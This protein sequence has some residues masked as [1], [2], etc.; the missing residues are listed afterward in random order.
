M[1][2][3]K[4]KEATLFGPE[5]VGP[6][7]DDGRVVEGKVVNAAKPK[8]TKGEVAVLPPPAPQN[9]LSIIASAAANPA[10][11]VAKMKELLAMQREIEVAEQERAF[12]AAMHA[13]QSEMPRITK[14][15]KADRFTYATLENVSLKIDPIARA[16]GFVL[17]YGSL[18]PATPGNI[19][20]YVDVMHVGGA[21]RR[22]IAP[23][24]KPDT[25]GLKDGKNKTD[26]QGAGASISYM[27]RYLKL[28]VFDVAIAGEDT[29]GKRKRGDEFIT[30]QQVELL[31]EQLEAVE[32]PRDK[33]L[34]FMKV[35][36]LA[37]IP[38]NLF[39]AGIDALK[40]FDEKRREKAAKGAA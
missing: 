26:T 35:E 34:A 18:P 17:S 27:R 4:A 40:A 33:F 15:K 28:M 14:D 39:Q 16:H 11:D 22:Y 21:V 7:A 9:M 6:K 1:A 3:T 8:K 25:V 20:M 5:A 10:V 37:D 2:K 36:R 32:C 12:N 19:A 24:I 38:K 23:E 30:Q 29:D 31:V 13:A